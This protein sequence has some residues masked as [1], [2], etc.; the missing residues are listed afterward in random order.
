MCQAAELEQQSEI[1]SAGTLN[2]SGSTGAQ[3]VLKSTSLAR[4]S[5][6][7]PRSFMFSNMDPAAGLHLD[8]L[9]EAEC[10]ATRFC[11]RVV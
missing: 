2:A 1:A 3:D 10:Q 4:Q 11:L 8:P 7:A 5:T 6:R 9:S